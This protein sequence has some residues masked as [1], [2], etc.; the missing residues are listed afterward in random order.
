MNTQ[1][2]VE[3]HDTQRNGGT[4]TYKSGTDYIL[5]VAFLLSSNYGIPR[6]LSGYDFNSH[7]QGP[8]SFGNW[9]VQVGLG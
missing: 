6:L 9:T 8:P 7:D 1:N 5:G 2:F 4:L 3:D